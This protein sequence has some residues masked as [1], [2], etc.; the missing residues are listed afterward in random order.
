MLRFSNPD[1]SVLFADKAKELSTNAHFDKGIAKALNLKGLLMKDHGKAAAAITQFRSSI[2]HYR[3]INDKRWMANGYNNTGLTWDDIGKKEEALSCYDSA[4]TLYQEISDWESIAETLNNFGQSYRKHG[5]YLTSLDY[6]LKSLKIYESN[7]AGNA[8]IKMVLA[9]IGIV[10][11]KMEKYPEAV[12]Y[13]TRAVAIAPPEDFVGLGITLS[14]L[15]NAYEQMGELA[16]SE[17][18]L[19][20]AK[21]LLSKADYKRGLVAVT[22]ELG[23]LK[24][25]KGEWKESLALLN[26]A[27]QIA[28]QSENNE[29][30]SIAYNNLAGV[31]SKL[32]DINHALVAARNALKIA[33]EYQIP[34]QIELAFKN[35]SEIFIR[36]KDYKNGYEY[37]F[38]YTNYRDSVFGKKKLEQFYELEKKYELD[39]KQSEINLL[40]KDAALKKVAFAA[41]QNFRYGLIGLVAGLCIF[42]GIVYYSVTTKASLNRKLQKQ[43]EEILKARALRAQINPHFIFNSLNSIQFLIMKVESAKAFDYLAKFGLLLRKIMDN[44]EKNLIPLSEEIEI[45]KLYVELESLRFDDSFEFKIETVVP[46]PTA[47]EVPPMVVQPYIENAILHGL[48]PKQGDRKLVVSFSQQNGSLLCEVQDNGIGRVEAMKVATRKSKLF[49]SKGMQYTSER[50]QAMNKFLNGK[51]EINI[52]DLND[53]GKAVG[54]LVKILFA[55]A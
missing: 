38:K 44:S 18:A 2:L 20:E 42:F 22:N 6:Y 49:A 34:E 30:Q 8:P 14:N 54:T 1:S 35:L 39:K 11:E 31:Y 10:Y 29:G 47:L 3:K 50:L 4:L 28:I 5:N 41:E 46:D 21:L 36:M 25:K 24:I 33:N 19:N 32:G 37:Y 23:N 13:Y 12:S 43:T 7:R 51:S 52:F 16:K 53:N 45:L 40:E 48:M 27:L 17:K 26:E 15:G 55:Y 9:N